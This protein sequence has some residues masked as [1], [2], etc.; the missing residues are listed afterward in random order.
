MYELSTYFP[1]AEEQLAVD[2]DWRPAEFDDPSAQFR[3]AVDL[4]YTHEGWLHVKDWKSGKQYTTHQGQAEMYAA[5]G[6]AKYS[7][8]DKV[9]VEMVYIDIPKVTMCWT[10]T[11]PRAAEIAVALNEE[12]KIVRADEEYLPTPSND[13]CRW[14]PLSW[15]NGGDCDKAP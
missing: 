8:I 14:C 10:Y 9:S 15:R 1:T 11:K 2:Y 6:L 4:S 13:A 5:L 12:A 3:G 7:D